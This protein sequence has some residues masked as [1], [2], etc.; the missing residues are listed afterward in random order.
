MLRGLFTL[1]SALSLLLLLALAGVWMWRRTNTAAANRLLDAAPVA[2]GFS[3]VTAARVTRPADYVIRKGDLVTV[4]L[5]D[6]QGPATNTSLSQRVTSQ[7]TI[8]LPFIGPVSAEGRTATD[9]G[10]TVVEAYNVAN[11]LAQ[12]QLDV[13]VAD[14]RP[15]VRA[16]W[17][18]AS[19]AVPPAI[20]LVVS[21]LM[22]HRRRR[23]A[24]VGRCAACGYDLRA[25]PGRCP[26]CG[27]HPVEERRGGR[28]R[29]CGRSR[30]AG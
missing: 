20:W 16:W 24:L 15:R 8:S 4:D 3:P 10:A 13:F 23:R 5:Y 18:A 22:A 1:L 25:S 14:E 7:G 2:V 12:A 21:V 9:L 28:R 27:R 29:G 11:I 19:F 30:L 26:E 17:L 6:L